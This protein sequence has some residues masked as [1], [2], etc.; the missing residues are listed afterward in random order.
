MDRSTSMSKAPRVP[1]WLAGAETCELC[2]QS[3]VYEEQ[4]RC[5]ACDAPLC[6]DC[7]VVVRETLEVLCPGCSPADDAEEA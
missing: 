3:Y 2:L 6:R 1:W 5:G 7:V 4:Y